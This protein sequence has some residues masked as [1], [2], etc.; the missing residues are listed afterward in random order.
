M[1]L[2]EYS[3]LAQ[4]PAR[5]ETIKNVFELIKEFLGFLSGNRQHSQ[6]PV[7]GRPGN[8]MIKLLVENSVF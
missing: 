7:F 2:K 5:V 8:S 1:I 3:E 6:V 4:E